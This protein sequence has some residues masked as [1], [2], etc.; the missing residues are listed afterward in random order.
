MQTVNHQGFLGPVEPFTD[1]NCK[2]AMA[3]PNVDHIDVFEGTEENINH[4]QSLV[5]K[6]YIV[7]KR[8][9]KTGSNKKKS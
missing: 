3:D 2:R 6:R 8:F 4:R 9:Q 7:K 1:T 5:G